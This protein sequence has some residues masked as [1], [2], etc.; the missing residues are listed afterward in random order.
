[1]KRLMDFLPGA[2]LLLVGVLLL[3]IP[4]NILVGIITS[5]VAVYLLILALRNLYYVVKVYSEIPSILKMSS[6]LKNAINIILPVIVIYLSFTNPRI[7]T[8]VIVYIIAFD[9]IVSALID[10]LDIRAFRKM[11]YMG[12]NYMD[13][14][15]HLMFALFMIFFPN[16]LVSTVKTIVAVILIILGVLFLSSGFYTFRYRGSRGMDEEVIDVKWEETEGK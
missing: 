14:I 16:I 7:I 5:I 1:M 6:L 12:M 2:S 10:A 9:L 8:S 11:G 3:V 13:V 4:Q 15:L